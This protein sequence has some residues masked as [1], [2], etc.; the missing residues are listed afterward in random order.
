MFAA[1][2]SSVGLS[3]DGGDRQ[4]FLQQFGL[5][6]DE[7]APQQALLDLQVLL[8]EDLQQAAA[9]PDLQRQRQMSHFGPVTMLGTDGMRLVN[10]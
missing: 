3:V 5:Q 9:Q 2:R 7:S 10:Q 8:R 4:S 1:S 6:L